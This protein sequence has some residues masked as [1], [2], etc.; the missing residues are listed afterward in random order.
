MR[1]EILETIALVVLIV[2]YGLLQRYVAGK[3]YFVLP[4]ILLG[5]GY[6]VYSCV[7]E[8]ATLLEYGI[9]TDNLLPSAKVSALVLA[10][11]GVV[12]LVIAARLGT[13][14]PPP[15]FYYLLALYPLWGIA[16]Q[17]FFQSLLHSRLIK[18]G[19]APWSILIVTILYASI[20]SSKLFVP[21]ILW[22]LIASTIFWRIPNILPLGVVHGLLG[23]MVYFLVLDQDVLQSFFESLG[24]R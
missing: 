22:G 7:R 5:V 2:L 18:L 24:A 4:A 20:H 23:A 12:I 13:L 19:L 9:R 21:T 11:G 6:A 16:Q 10:I 17:F 15:S 3:A 1:K 8:P 14:P